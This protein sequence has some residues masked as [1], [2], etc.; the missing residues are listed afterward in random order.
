MS[1]NCKAVCVQHGARAP[2]ARIIR[3]TALAM[4]LA[5]AAAISRRAGIR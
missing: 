1:I 2:A 5:L 3:L 4:P